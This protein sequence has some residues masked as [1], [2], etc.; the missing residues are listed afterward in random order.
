MDSFILLP[1]LVIPVAMITYYLGTTVPAKELSEN[2]LF[3]KLIRLRADRKLHA[4][5]KDE[6]EKEIETLSDRFVSVRK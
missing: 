2:E 6:L 4:I 1:L 3:E 5:S